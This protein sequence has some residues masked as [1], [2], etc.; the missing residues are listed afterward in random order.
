MSNK[1]YEIQQETPQIHTYEEIAPDT[2]NGQ[3]VQFT[4][5]EIHGAKNHLSQ[6][7]EDSQSNVSLPYSA[8]IRIDKQEHVAEKEAVVEPEKAPSVSDKQ[9]CTSAP[10]PMKYKPRGRLLKHP[11]GHRHSYTENTCF[12]PSISEDR[13]APLAPPEGTASSVD[14]SFQ[15]PTDTGSNVAPSECH[16]SVR[17]AADPLNVS[18]HTN[19]SC[20][21]LSSVHSNRNSVVEEKTSGTRFFLAWFGWCA[22]SPVQENSYSSASAA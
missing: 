15:L 6:G 9:S 21:A 5:D 18:R 20:S 2:E 12:P 7:D 14:S 16:S 4:G 1:R 8:V 3:E 13:R 10:L 19:K 11:P 22:S 17:E